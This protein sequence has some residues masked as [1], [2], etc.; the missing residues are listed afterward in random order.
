MDNIN[1]ILNSSK[2]INE[3]YKKVTYFDE[4]GGSVF[5]FILLTILLFI[6]YSYS[7]VMLNI[8]P[9]KEDWPAQR[10]NPK[11]IPF[12]GL[13]NR[14]AGMSVSEYTSQNFQYCMQNILVSITGYAV[15]PITY[16]T[17]LLNNIFAELAEALYFINN[18]MANIRTSIA[19][20][21]Q[22]VMDR[23]ANVMVPLQHILIVIKDLMGKIKGIF[24]GA[25]YT[26]LGTYYALKSFLGAIGQI[27]ILM[28]VILAA[29]IIGFW[30]IPF[31]WP[32]AI[33]M[34][35]IFVSVSIPL[36]I[37]LGFM[38]E[39]LHVQIDSP[40][41]SMPS[42]PN[43]CFDKNSMLKM[44]DG[45][46]KK[47]VDIH[48]G[49]ILYGDDMVTAK[50]TL[51]STNMDMYNVDG[52]IVSGFHR[53]KYH[54]IWIPVLQHPHSHLIHNYSEPFLYCLNTRSKTI[55]INDC[56]FFDWDEVEK[57]ELMYLE[58]ILKEKYNN[59]TISEEEKIDW[60]HNYLDGGFSPSTM[61]TMQNNTQKEMTDICI[62][63]VLKNGEIVC[64]IVEID[65]VH[66][67][68]QFQF[69]LGDTIVE[70][71]PNLQ[72]CDNSAE[73]FT[74]TLDIHQMNNSIK[75]Y[76]SNSISKSNKLYHLLTNTGT[77]FIKDIQFY[78]YNSVLDLFL[79]N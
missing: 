21:G 28:L 16:A 41:P 20:L 15:Q 18:M 50:L 9:I 37:M 7:V 48:P 46:K 58:F 30:I 51:D 54:G 29:L 22:N 13:I 56:I 60:I 67:I 35:A 74:S 31:T 53:I 24:T 52:V 49:D 65:G 62:H 76:F 23:V 79:D 12:A 45:K 4:Y 19:T 34:T 71:G 5:L 2:K 55:T 14:P 11:I 36:A 70:G 3:M 61:V 17:S 26:S 68:N 8:K 75:Q 64:G 40:I 1:D 77:F 39:V 73:S 6:G 25:L 47:I 44:N 57:K 69:H 10:C 78:H 43:M 59:V 27:I 42:K 33:T 66:I 38:S 32:V 63:D 72:I